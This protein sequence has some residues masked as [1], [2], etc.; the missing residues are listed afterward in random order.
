MP[1]GPICLNDR[2]ED[3]GDHWH[4]HSGQRRNEGMSKWTSTADG[5]AL[6]QAK[7][8]VSPEATL[9]LSVLAWEIPPGTESTNS[10][11]Y[12]LSWAPGFG[13]VKLS[14]SA[15]LGVG[16]SGTNV[17]KKLTYLPITQ[18]EQSRFTGTK[19]ESNAEKV[20]IARASGKPK[21]AG[22]FGGTRLAST[23]GQTYT[24]DNQP[25]TTHHRI[26]DKTQRAGTSHA[27][28]E[29]RIAS[30]SNQIGSAGEG[31]KKTVGVGLQGIELD[32]TAIADRRVGAA[33]PYPS[34]RSST[35]RP[36]A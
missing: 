33:P 28:D 31:D 13:A 30:V 2:N 29:T 19:G 18:E 11:N 3:R 9:S 25:D 7:V 32:I 4:W 5:R 26:L 6:T 20:A 15:Y 17:K 22:A 16:S 27:T 10:E 1:E 21:Q 24:P 23:N 35:P 34:A 12:F 36:V 14:S 8:R